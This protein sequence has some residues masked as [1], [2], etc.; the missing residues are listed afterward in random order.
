VNEKE[1]EYAKML[2]IIREGV[3]KCKNKMAKEM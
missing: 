3:I 1:R 2:K